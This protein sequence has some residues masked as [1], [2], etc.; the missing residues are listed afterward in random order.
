MTEH[1]T[2]TTSHSA[3]H[4][5]IVREIGRALRASAPPDWQ[6]IRL[7]YRATVEIGEAD[8][9]ATATTGEVIRWDHPIECVMLFDHLREGMR[10]AK[11]GTWFTASCVINRSGNCTMEFDYNSAP[12]WRTP[13]PPSAY[14]LDLQRFPRSEEHTPPWLREQRDTARSQ[15]VRRL[16][17][18]STA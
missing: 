16:D 9:E 3:E 12:S 10:R 1:R 14:L 13:I 7:H 18:I 5:E 17:G 6:E 11:E 2:N 8:L 15:R 4:A